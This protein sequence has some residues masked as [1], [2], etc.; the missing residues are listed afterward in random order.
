M[1]RNLCAETH[2]GFVA[3]RQH[4]TMNI[5]PDLSHAGAIVWRNQ[6]MVSRD[7]ARIKAAWATCLAQSVEPFYLAI[8][9]HWM[10]IWPRL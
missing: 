3:L 4:C 1:E 9:L 2:S 7:V 6:P 5:G 8:F 10:H